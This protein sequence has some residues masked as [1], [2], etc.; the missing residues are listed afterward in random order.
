M[1]ST[2]GWVRRA[3]S[4]RR[5]REGRAPNRLPGD[6]SRP[7]LHDL[8]IGASPRSRSPSARPLTRTRAPLEKKFLKAF[9]VTSWLLFLRRAIDG[10][11]RHIWKSKS[12][13]NGKLAP[14]AGRFAEASRRRRQ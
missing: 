4:G 10:A 12:V 5:A 14:P 11:N 2:T 3:L 13:F 1:P 7:P 9:V 8:G 6:R